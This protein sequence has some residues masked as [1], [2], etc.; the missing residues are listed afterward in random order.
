M[1]HRYPDIPNWLTLRRGIIALMHYQQVDDVIDSSV[2]G[3]HPDTDNIYE[4]LCTLFKASIYGYTRDQN[5]ACA[6]EFSEAGWNFWEAIKVFVNKCC[7]L[8]DNVVRC[9]FDCILRWHEVATFLTEDLLVCSFWASKVIVPPNYAWAPFLDT[10]NENLNNVLNKELAD[11]HAHLAG[12]SLNFDINWMCLMNHI[13]QREVVFDEIQKYFLNHQILLKF[14][15]DRRDFYTLS[16]LAAAIRIHLFS[17][18]VNA[19]VDIEEDLRLALSS[20]SQLELI[21]FKEKIQNHIIILREMFGYK[22]ES[23][24]GECTKYDY[25]GLPGPSEGCAYS[26]LSGERFIMYG[27]LKNIFCNK[28]P[29]WD[30]TLFY[31]YLLIKHRIRHELIQT[32][33]EVGFSNFQSYQNRKNLFIKGYPDYS[34]L[35]NHL[36]VASLFAGHDSNR[37]HETRITPNKSSVKCSQLIEK[38]EKNINNPKLKRNDNIWNYGYIFHFIKQSNKFSPDTINLE[39]LH[40]DLRGKVKAMAKAIIDTCKLNKFQPSYMKPFRKIVGIDAASSEIDC[41][42]EVF[43]HAFRYI[44]KLDKNMG[45]TYHVGEDFYDLAD[46]LRA[47]DECILFMNF[48]R[49]DRLGHA[50]ALG[51]DVE[52]YLSRRRYV[53]SM[54]KQVAIDNYVWLYMKLRHKYF[55][56]DVANYLYKE[57]IKL[58]KELYIQFDNIPS[59]ESYYYSWMLRGDAPE[60][61]NLDGSLNQ[62]GEIDIDWFNTSLSMHPDVNEARRDVEARKLF[63]H[64]HLDGDL[65]MKGAKITTVKYP[66]EMIKAIKKVQKI[67][68]EK[69]ELLGL[70]IECNPTSNYKIGDIWRYDEHPIK[71]FY[72]KGL[73]LI[74]KRNISCSINTDDKGVFATSIE[75]EYALMAAALSRKIGIKKY[76]NKVITWLDRIRINSLKQKFIKRIEV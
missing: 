55:Y 57:Y 10:D 1:L 65:K 43:A 35:L 26:T 3:L 63:Y 73:S 21:Q 5:I 24:N 11:I 74:N 61:Y 41:R 8:N 71:T 29:A 67:M 30:S 6:M 51:I 14:G 20:K 76:N 32:N 75:R 66:A 54:P 42:P 45:G 64:Y 68:L 60:R 22:Y 59:I 46:G 17:K 4:Q 25:A 15:A 19:G 33:D 7:D 52:Q 47:I 39:V 40:S 13:E 56:R 36:S 9:R 70:A 50:L 53:I 12:S 2:S 37:W 49:G 48:H 38:L 44:L 27:T 62:N 72:S 69:V 28:S 34:E 31:I 18:L 58:A 23:Y 16:I